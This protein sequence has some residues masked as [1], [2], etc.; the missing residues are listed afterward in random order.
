MTSNTLTATD[1]DRTYENGLILFPE[2]FARFVSSVLND[3]NRIPSSSDKLLLITK[4][5]PFRR[6]HGQT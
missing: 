3:E 2:K 6:K 1:N 5:T 4:K